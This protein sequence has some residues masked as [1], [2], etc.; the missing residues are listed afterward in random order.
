MIDI[1]QTFTYAKYLSKTGWIAKREKG[2]N[3][4]IKRFPLIGSVIKIQRPKIIDFEY[5][6]KLVKKN[7][8]FQI[9][10]EPDLNTHI[11]SFSFSHNQKLT[12]GNSTSYHNL[13]YNLGFKLSKSPYLP[14]KTLQLDLNK[15]EK[16]LFDGLKKDCRYALRRNSQNLVSNYQ[17]KDIGKFREYW[18]KA[19]G[20]RRYIPSLSHLYALKKFFGKNCLFLG[21]NSPK[22][23][24]TGAIFLKT[25]DIGYYWQAFTNRAGRKQLVQYKIVWEG[26]L[27]AKKKGVK[28]FD[29][30]GIYDERFPNKSW[31]GFTHFKESFGGSEIKYPGCFSIFKIPFSI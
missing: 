15:S 22:Q 17:L 4:F 31:L 24:Y 2:V 6:E 21:I 16:T 13:L 1:R 11:K 20:T 5:I 27:W 28:I 29:F 7:K 8:A 26:I 25:K 12:T 18:K 30:E 10:L 9:I 19:A 23:I 14:T 3:Y